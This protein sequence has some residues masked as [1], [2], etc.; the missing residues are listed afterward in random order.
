MRASK[1][2]HVEAQVELSSESPLLALQALLDGSPLNLSH[3]VGPRQVIEGLH[4]L[5]SIFQGQALHV[6][7]G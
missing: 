2:A 3:E 7:Y 5:A 4:G 1:T 6:E